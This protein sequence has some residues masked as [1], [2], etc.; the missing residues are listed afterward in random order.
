MFSRSYKRMVSTTTNG[1]GAV[2]DRRE[3]WDN[4]R[5]LTFEAKNLRR[6]R[7][8]EFKEK[9]IERVP[10]YTKILEKKAE[11]DK[12]NSKIN[13]LVITR[14]AKASCL[15]IGMIALGAIGGG[16]LGG[17][18]IGGWDECAPFFFLSLILAVVG[19]IMAS[20]KT[21]SQAVVEENMII[22]ERLIKERDVLQKQLEALEEKL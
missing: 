1:Y 18:M 3:Y 14:T 4:D 8:N 22:R 12:M 13:S 11:I 20:I 5:S 6:A 19:I 7:N 10:S 17:F 2:T 15:A 16:L 21:P 9:I